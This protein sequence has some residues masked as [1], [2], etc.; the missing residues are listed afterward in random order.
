MAFL[1]FGVVQAWR[2]FPWSG[3]L[4]ASSE[5]GAFDAGAWF[6]AELKT[7][8]DPMAGTVEVR[9]NTVPV[10]TL[11]AA[12]TQASGRALS[13]GIVLGC[14]LFND[15]YTAY[16]MDDLYVCDLAGGVNDDFLGNARVQALLAAGP[17]SLTDF[18]PNGALANWQ[19]VLDE[20]LSDTVYVSDPTVGDGDLY[21][22]AP[23]VNNPTVFGVQVKGAYRQT[24]A[25][26]RFVKNQLKASGTLARG[27]SSA[28]YQTYAFFAD[29]W[30][31]N[32]G[33]GLAFTGAQ[34]NAAEVGPYIDA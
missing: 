29:I 22:V 30:E 25:T 9:V 23:L 24:D 5:I 31:L 19:C 1:P 3:A 28:T 11:V 10:N 2:G 15:G 13:D 8:I 16:A 7:V 26:Q 20:T 6:Y 18:T 27:A 33:T 21:A 32:P 14:V 17:G 4:L 12:N 34:V